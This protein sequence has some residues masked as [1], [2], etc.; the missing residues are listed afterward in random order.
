MVGRI[1]WFVIVFLLIVSMKGVGQDVYF[2]QAIE[3]QLYINPAFTGNTK[4]SRFNLLYRNQWPSAEKA[5]VTYVA[6]FDVNVESIKSGF[7]FYAMNDRQGNGAYTFSTA[8]ILY[9]YNLH[10]SKTVFVRFG[11]EGSF[12]QVRLNWQQLEFAD[13]ID[14]VT[15]DI[16]GNTQELLPLKTSVNKPDF[17]TGIIVNQLDKW[18]V[19]LAVNHLL[20]PELSF[21]NDTENRLPLKVSLQGGI[22]Y[23][24]SQKKLGNFEEKNLLLRLN[25]L[26]LHQ[27]N[28]NMINAGFSFEKEPVMIG[29]MYR[30]NLGGADALAFLFSVKIKNVK[31]GYS[32]DFS[33]SELNSYNG[34]AHE[35]S[36]KWEF[37]AF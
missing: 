19:G 35:V 21:Y 33:L 13:Q 23:N 34:G 4:C 2:T 25:L 22:N 9:S 17:S 15:G 30:N 37:C 12:L 10:V 28:F 3:N 36:L 14:P 29:V 7:G 24:I 18:Y 20:Q 16:M 1:K 11:L 31:V 6:S 26:Y 27:Q 5:Y 8:S 32:Y